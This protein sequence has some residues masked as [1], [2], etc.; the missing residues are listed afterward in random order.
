MRSL[1]QTSLLTE[2][3]FAVDLEEIH[4]LKDRLLMAWKLLY[5]NR[6]ADTGQMPCWAMFRIV[7]LSCDWWVMQDWFLD[8]LIIL[9]DT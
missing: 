1:Y 3:L 6:K 4:H 5:P 7:F 8:P 9:E 2:S